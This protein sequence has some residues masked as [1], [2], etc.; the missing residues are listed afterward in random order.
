MSVEFRRDERIDARSIQPLT[1]EFRWG[2]CWGVRGGGG[3]PGSRRN[4]LSRHS[5]YAQVYGMSFGLLNDD[6]NY[7]ECFYFVNKMDDFIKAIRFWQV[8]LLKTLRTD[9]VHSYKIFSYLFKFL[10]CTDVFL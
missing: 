3:P 6:M 7:P 8:D 9:T 4:Y 10:S 5:K 1:V 2:R